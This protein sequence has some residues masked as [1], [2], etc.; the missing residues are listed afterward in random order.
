[1]VKTGRPRLPDSSRRDVFRQFKLTEAEDDLVR[2]AAYYE[3]MSV[4]AWC[5]KVVLE[6][7]VEFRNVTV[8]LQ[9][10]RKKQ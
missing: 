1:M 7:A 10:K 2:E 6:A 5:R 9:E 8:S 3:C 4:P